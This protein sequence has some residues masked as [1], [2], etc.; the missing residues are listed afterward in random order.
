MLDSDPWAI[1]EH[2]VTV[3]LGGVTKTATYRVNESV[4]DHVQAEDFYYYEGDCMGYE[5]NPDVYTYDPDCIVF[6]K[7]GTSELSNYGKVQDITLC[8]VGFDRDRGSFTD[9]QSKN[10]W[11]VGVH[12]V[13]AVPFNRFGAKLDGLATTFK[14]EIEAKGE[15]ET[16]D[17]NADGEI[18]IVDATYVQRCAAGMSEMSPKQK[19]A[20]DLN[21]DGVVDVIDAT[22]IQMKLAFG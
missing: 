21:G 1:G 9:D 22:L 20:A 4:I 8:N 6:Y 12:T 10:P 16:A 11:G 19:A 18:T 14:V 7:D 2:T 3:T 15:V 13:R 17:A 5:D